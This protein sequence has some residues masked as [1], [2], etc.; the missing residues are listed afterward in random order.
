MFHVILVVSAVFGLFYI[1]VSIFQCGNPAKIGDSFFA[2]QKCIPS[3]VGLTSGYVYGVVNV[4]ADWTFV[5]V[6]IVVLLDSEMDRRSKISVSIVMGL[7]AIGSIASILRMVYLE[8]LQLSTGG[9]SG[10]WGLETCIF[11]MPN[12]NSAAS[13]KATIWATAEPGTGIIAASIAIM[14]PLIRKIASDTRRKQGEF[15]CRKASLPRSIRKIKTTDSESVIAL[16]NVESKDSSKTSW[17]ATEDE[18]VWSPTVTVGEAYA[19]KVTAIKM[20]NGKPLP[21]PPL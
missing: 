1:L 8:G 14:R 16:T 11:S 20:N 7:G 13:V 19:Q 12:S 17:Y 2:S 15:H 6:P 21:S 18:D 10:E 3:G 4:L 9:I 5:L